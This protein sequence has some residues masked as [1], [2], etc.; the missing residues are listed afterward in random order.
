MPNTNGFAKTLYANGA[1]Q[2]EVP[3][4]R[5][6]LENWAAAVI[7]ATAQVNFAFDKSQEPHTTPDEI[8]DFFGVSKNT[9][10]QKAQIIRSSLKCA[11]GMRNSAQ[12]R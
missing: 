12:P 3:F 4:V 6:R 2:R 8:A 11:T 5:G 10:S 9:A 7:Y 1:A